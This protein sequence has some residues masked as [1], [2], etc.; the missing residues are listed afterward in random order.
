[1]RNSTD[2]A[3]INFCARLDKQRYDQFRALALVFADGVPERIVQVNGAQT[4]TDI[5]RVLS[6]LLNE[7][8]ASH[9]SGIEQACQPSGQ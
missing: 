1:V 5:D 2:K 4:L 7:C 9:N 3:H 6:Q 8:A